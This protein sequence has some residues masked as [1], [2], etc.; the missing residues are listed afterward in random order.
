MARSFRR[1]QLV[2]AVFA[3]G[4]VALIGRAAHVQLLQGAHHATVA[5]AQ[6]TERVELPARRGTL[7]D[8][9]GTALAL[10]QEVYHLGVAP[11]ELIDPPADTRTIA[12]VLGIPLRTVQQRLRARWAYFAGPYNSLDVQPLRGM[13]GVH[14]EGEQVR[15]HP[16]PD[17]ARSLLGHPAVEGRPASGMERVLDTLLAGTAGTAVVLRDRHGVRYES[18]ARLDA[19]PRPG[20][21]VYLTLDG[22][23]QEIVERALSDALEQYDATA[24][25]MVVMDPVSGEVLA[26]ASAGRGGANALTG[27]FEPGSTAKL[28]AAAALLSHGLVSPLDSVSTEGGEYDLNGR[29]IHDDHPDEEWLD[30]AGVFQHSSNIGMV[31]LAAR[32]TPEQQ[33]EMLRDFGLGTPTGVEYP[34]ESGGRLKPPAQWSGTTPASLAMG[35]ELAV[36]ALQLAQ[37]YAAVANDGLMVQPTL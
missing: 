26:I 12:E 25:D 11:N 4:F 28:F 16:H 32:L 37:A 14:L 22:D 10:T 24:G 5:A 2:Q 18:P 19:F 33:Y 7:F 3:V 17:L 20:H 9:K 1:L 6:R 8:R 31:K 13:R 36:T 27:V 15:F 34:A 23:L 21:D 35:Y 30:L 29:V